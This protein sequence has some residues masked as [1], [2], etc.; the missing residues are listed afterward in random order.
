[1]HRELSVQVGRLEEVTERTFRFGQG[2]MEGL[3]CFDVPSAE[4]VKQLMRRAT[5]SL[6]IEAAGAVGHLY[7]PDYIQSLEQH[8][9][10]RFS[11]LKE[12][13]KQM[14][15]QSMAITKLVDAFARLDDASAP[16]YSVS[17]SVWRGAP[18]TLP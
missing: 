16:W 6:V 10:Y 13:R 18:F 5:S 11:F 4:P 1:M 15:S 2:V 14:S 9:P 7:T 12:R 8:S 17:P 3:G